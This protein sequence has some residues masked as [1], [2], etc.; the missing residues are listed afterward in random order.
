MKYIIQISTPPKFEKFN[1]KDLPS[2]NDR[3]YLVKSKLAINNDD[4][5]SSSSNNS[6]TSSSD[7]S[8]KYLSEQLVNE[9]IEK[10]IDAPKNKTP[11]N[12]VEELLNHENYIK[13][14]TYLEKH[15]IK[16]KYS[17]TANGF[18]LDC[19]QKQIE[20]IIDSNQKIIDLIVK[21]TKILL[22]KPLTINSNKINT[23]RSRQWGLDV[24]NISP[25]W[26]KNIKGQNA[27]IALFD[28]GVDIS[29]CQLKNNYSGTWKDF[30]N[31]NSDSNEENK[32]YKNK[33]SK[34]YDDNGHGTFICGLICG[35][36][37]NDF[38]IGVAPE[39]KWLCYKILDHNGVGT[40]SSFIE[41]CDD[42]ITNRI[43]PDAIN[44]SFDL[45]S[46]GGK[47]DHNYI[48]ILEGIISMLES[49][50]IFICF[51]A[52]NSNNNNSVMKYP[53]C[54]SRI[55]SVGAFDYGYKIAP[56]N[57]YGIYENIFK[58]D[59]VS[60]GTNIVSCIPSKYLPDENDI[61]LY[62]NSKYKYCMFSSTS[63]AS[64]YICG[65]IALIVQCLNRKKIEYNIEIIKDLLTQNLFKLS[66]DKK[67][68][69]EYTQS[70]LQNEKGKRNLS[71]SSTIIKSMSKKN[72][73]I[74]INKKYKDHPIRKL[75]KPVPRLDNYTINSL[76]PKFPYLN[77]S[78]L[79][80][81]FEK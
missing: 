7:G 6:S 76:H 11:Q 72:E 59:I 44:C 34:P 54:L 9:V 32:E 61:I 33:K 67:Y 26:D 80:H 46:N 24:I 42:L 1:R 71:I 36:N 50:N 20:H 29:H 79:Y 41:A 60:P 55:F 68:D 47:I 52:G 45:L 69:T 10:I 12:P 53:G 64:A 73:S 31:S 75:I 78:W 81:C 37:N 30:V 28:T 66:Q 58:P 57:C 5:D 43:Y 39:A 23:V 3:K 15:N 25:L 21:D 13:M 22:H 19:S 77:L 51:S 4:S 8:S 49:Y 65:C 40:F 56:F 16:Y 63:F 35:A 38:I 74:D 48:I 62:D 27:L 70:D 17:I 18:I 2:R 14:S